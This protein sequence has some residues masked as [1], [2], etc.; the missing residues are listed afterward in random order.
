[1]FW[2]NFFSYP[3][4]PCGNQKNSPT[5]PPLLFRR[6]RWRWSSSSQLALGVGMSDCNVSFEQKTLAPKKG[7]PFG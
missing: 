6:F 7:E 4:L 5:H 3:Q 2:K 1:M